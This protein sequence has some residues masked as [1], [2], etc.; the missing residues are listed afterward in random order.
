[1]LFVVD[2]SNKEELPVDANNDLENKVHGSRLR[3]VTRFH[4]RIRSTHGTLRNSIGFLPS[5]LFRSLSFLI[6]YY[7]LG[8]L[9][10]LFY[11]KGNIKVFIFCATS[12]FI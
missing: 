12:Y 2:L 3:W 7:S 1:M 4:E 6:N 10:E 5:A 8:S 9:L 11:F